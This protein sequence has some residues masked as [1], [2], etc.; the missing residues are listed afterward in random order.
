MPRTI[1]FR[2]AL[3]V[4]HTIL[5]LFFGGIGLFLRDAI[6]SRPFLGS[7]SAY[8][9]TLRYHVWPWPLKFAEILNMPAVL[10]DAIPAWVIDYFRPGLPEWTSLLPVL[11]FVPLL[12]FAVGAYLDRTLRANQLKSPDTAWNLCLFFIA[13]S[14][15]AAFI[16]PGAP[17]SPTSFVV[18]G[19]LLWTALA[20]AIAAHALLTRFRSSTS[21]PSAKIQK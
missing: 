14:A 11:I 8:E 5:A 1:Q 9:T 20:I 7:P 12:W 15:A 17:F 4:V 21:A 3:P 10:A 16:P 6:L 13:I 19:A 18:F 2:K